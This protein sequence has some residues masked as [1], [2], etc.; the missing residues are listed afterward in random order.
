MMHKMLGHLDLH[1]F[2]KLGVLRSAKSNSGKNVSIAAVKNR[3]TVKRRQQTDA[4]VQ[5]SHLACP[6]AVLSF[7]WPLWAS[8]TLLCTSS[9]TP[10]SKISSANDKASSL[11]SPLS[12][13]IHSFE[14]LNVWFYSYFALCG[15]VQNSFQFR[16]DVFLK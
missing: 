15:Q 12:N 8:M 6:S 10:S 14:R 5:I 9:S 11:A 2:N 4:G 13:S 1:S 16:Q 7:S 3:R